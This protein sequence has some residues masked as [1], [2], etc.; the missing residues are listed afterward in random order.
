MT[1]RLREDIVYR[2]GLTPATR[3][4]LDSEDPF[5]TMPACNACVAM[6]SDLSLLFPHKRHYL[7]ILSGLV[8]AGDAYAI[9]VVHN[10]S[11][12]K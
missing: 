8:K 4:L 10:G 2:Q 9:V 5:I 7:S 11:F 12:V 1:R 6:L 3:K